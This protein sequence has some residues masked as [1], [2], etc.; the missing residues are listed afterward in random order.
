[1]T[2]SVQFSDEH[3]YVNDNNRELLEQLI[4]TAAHH[5]RLVG[6]EVSVSFVNNDEIRMLNRDYR[7]KDRPT[8]VL[9]FP[10][11]E[12]E[13]L[14]QWQA[15]DETNHMTEHDGIPLLLGDIIISIPKAK[16]QAEEY[17]HSL[18]RELGFLLIH[19]FLHLLGYDH[20]DE[21]SESKMFS[22]QEDILKKH[23]LVR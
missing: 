10:M 20:E 13:E 11:Y 2:V 23:G 14:Q 8:D 1:M 4:N 21:S 22:L 7:E 9:S 15:T 19:G 12:Q 17:N 3:N 5:M 18:E 16:E 6:G